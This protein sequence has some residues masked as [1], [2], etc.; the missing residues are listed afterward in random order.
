MER[1]QKM[2]NY[3]TGFLCAMTILA[4]VGGCSM[5][6]ENR[7]TV[8]GGDP[9]V[10]RCGNGERIEARYY[11]LSD[12][13][14]DFVKVR[15]PDGKEYTVPRVLSASGVRYTDDMELVWWT[16]GDSAFAEMRDANGDWQ[17]S[18][19]NCMASPGK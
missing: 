12:N 4:G 10:Y 3:C 7:L 19:D 16:K 2:R 5:V 14:L 15:I 17:T 6:Q 13:S 1:G 11:A 9:V 18:Y 8:Q